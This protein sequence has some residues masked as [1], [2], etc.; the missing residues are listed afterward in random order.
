[1]KGYSF[2]NHLRHTLTGHRNWPAA[3][4]SPEP[5]KTYDVV[6]IGGGGHGLATAYHLAKK[7][8][9]D[10]VAVVEK[11]WLGGGNVAA[12]LIMQVHDELVFEVDEDAVDEVAVRVTQ[13]MQGAASLDVPLTVEVGRGANW[14]EAH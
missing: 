6:I 7:H 10:N 11:G 9:I 2:L 5:K 3:W 14:D 12:D 13:I 8:G 4:R 1:M